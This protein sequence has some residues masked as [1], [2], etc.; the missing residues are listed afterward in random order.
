MQKTSPLPFVHLFLLLLPFFPGQNGEENKYIEWSTDIISVWEGDSAHI[1]CSKNSSEV[2]VGTY[3]RTRTPPANIVYV[4][5]TNTSYIHPDFANRTKYLN[6][7]TNL[8]ITVHSVKKSDSNIYLCT[9]YIKK[10]GYHVR[11][12]GKTIIMVVK[13]KTNG[14][15]E[16]SPLSVSTRQGESINITC[17]LKNSQEDEAFILLRNHMQ[18]EKVLYVSSQ[19]TSTIFPT[20][21][22]R[23]EYSKQEKKL[24]ITLHNLQK[25][26]TDI[27]VCAATLKNSSVSVS[28]SGTMV[29]VK[30]EEQTECSISSLAIYVPT[31]AAVLLLFALICYILQHVD[32]KKYFQKKKI[33]VVYEDMSFSSRSNTL[34]RTNMYATDN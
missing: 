6:E 29:L 19:N 22:N 9:N 5:S 8:K 27:Y 12:E 24:V 4:S 34:V 11:R 23:L 31:I 21:A 14:V 7:E 3:L 13:A 15:I 1:T 17:V 28:E 30:G 10:N 25:N 33:N 2:E 18:H 16:Q 26:D 20:F 32:M